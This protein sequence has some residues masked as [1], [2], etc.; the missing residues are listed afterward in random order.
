M[1]MQGHDRISQKEL[2]AARDLRCWPHTLKQIRGPSAH[3]EENSQQSCKDAMSCASQANIIVAE[4]DVPWAHQS[5]DT[6]TQIL[7]IVSPGE[8]NACYIC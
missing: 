7:R 6:M 5:F 8:H 1:V 3:A 4:A 2:Q